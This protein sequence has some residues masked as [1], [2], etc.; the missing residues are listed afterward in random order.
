MEG[1]R[2]SPVA[3]TTFLTPFVWDTQKSQW[4]DASDHKNEIKRITA[5]ETETDTS[6]DNNVLKLLQYNILMTSQYLKE[7]MT[8]LV[9]LIVEHKADI[10]C[11]QEAKRKHVKGNF[12]IIYLVIYLFLKYLCEM[13]E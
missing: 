8:A 7:R 6:S 5:D 2:G 4:T 1:G 13:K 12:F 10:I 9:D 11:M 3:A